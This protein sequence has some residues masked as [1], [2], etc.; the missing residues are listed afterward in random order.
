[1]GWA[2]KHHTAAAGDYLLR[3]L[4]VETTIHYSRFYDATDATEA[5]LLS[6]MGHGPE[7][8]ADAAPDCPAA[9]VDN[10]V[11]QL[12]EAG[13]VVTRRTGGKLADGEP[14]YEIELTP[15]G[16]EFAASGEKF[17]YYDMDL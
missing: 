2:Y 3:L 10:A 11:G 1:M 4:I 13:L 12:E 16:R 14:A 6:G 5:A 7:G 17:P 8:D 15:A 9:Y